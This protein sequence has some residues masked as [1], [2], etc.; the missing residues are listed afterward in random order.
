[1]GA[2]SNRHLITYLPLVAV[3]TLLVAI[4][5]VALVWWLRA[6]EI[7]NSFWV[8]A[9]VSVTVVFVIWHAGGA[10]W[11]TRSGSHDIL[12]SELLLWGWMQRWRNDRRLDAAADVLGLASRKPQAVP[13][14]GL[15]N[16]H[17]ADLLAQLSTTLEARD[18]YTH[19]HSR[20][21]ARHA[22]N[23]ARR[24]GLPSEEVTK[25]RAA[26]VMHDVGKLETPKA[27]LHKDGKLTD[28]EFA[29]IK[30]HPVDGALM[31]ATLE[32]DEL[33]ALVRHH[34]ERID[35]GGYPDGLMGDQ[36]PLGARIIAVADTFDAVTSTRAYRRAHA[37]K[38]ALDILT[39]EAGSQLD[40]GA[41]RAFCACY[42]GR[43][44]LAV[45]TMVSSGAPRLASWSGG[46]VGSASAGSLAGVVATVAAVL[47][48]TTLGPTPDETPAARGQ[49][50]A[51]AAASTA[52]AD[53]ERATGAPERRV[54]RPARE[55]RENR[56]SRSGGPG[57]RADRAVPDPPPAPTPAYSPP[58]AP[59]SVPTPALAPVAA[60]TPPP[61]PDSPQDTGGDDDGRGGGQGRDKDRPGGQGKGRGNGGGKGER[62]RNDNGNGPG[63]ERRGDRGRP[64]RDQDGRQAP[65]I[66]NGRDP[67]LG[68]PNTP[69]AGRGPNGPNNGNGPGND[70][71]PGNGQVLPTD[72]VLP[73]EEVGRGPSQRPARLG[74]PAG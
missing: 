72:P 19:G 60:P 22:T 51:T 11:K 49:G 39:A 54:A 34:H 14:A 46:G 68:N 2:H 27:V 56:E 29:V 7:I 12:F 38:K 21:V 9:A 3:T 4:L 73:L 55:A 64:D 30:R 26:A 36:I 15:T 25:I 24:M 67:S 61:T 63:Q 74:P 50:P 28:E 69:D 1:M 20:R 45:W 52:A 57:P 32:D 66:G 65:G 59:V 17:K 37:H 31:V 47:A 33:T 62:P 48:G 23:I 42:S 53:P 8:G 44:P 10:L 70:N 18:P 43:R 6:A 40:A 16:E 13:E 35:G 71:G 58:A 5:P 41:V